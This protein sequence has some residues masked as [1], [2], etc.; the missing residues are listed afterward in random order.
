MH[1]LAIDI[2]KCELESYKQCLRIQSKYSV[3][4]EYSG[5]KEDFSGF[6][7]D[8]QGAIDKLVKNDEILVAAD[9]DSSICSSKEWTDKPTDISKGI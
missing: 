1:S 3:F 6:I 7:N 8:L 4:P 9:N 5:G 2:L